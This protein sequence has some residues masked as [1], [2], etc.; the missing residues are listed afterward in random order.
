MLEL[1]WTTH[2]Q[3]YYLLKRGCYLQR[4]RIFRRRWQ[5]R[6]WW[7]NLPRLGRGQPR[8]GGGNG[9][10]NKQ[11]A[12]LAERVFLSNIIYAW[13]CIILNRE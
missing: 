6:A 8:V 11:D 2:L 13:I 10:M 4:P 1:Q 12:A 9:I 7:G 5:S 3:I